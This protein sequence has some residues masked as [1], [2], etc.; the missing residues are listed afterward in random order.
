[1]K[2]WKV[3][4]K[5]YSSEIPFILSGPQSF[6]RHVGGQMPK[7]KVNVNQLKW[8]FAWVI[9]TIKAILMQ[10]FSVVALSDLEIRRHKISLGR[11]EQV[12]KFR[13]LSLENGF[14]FYKISF[15]AQN[16]SSRHKIDHHVNLSNSSRVK[17]FNFQ[18]FWD[19]LMRKE[20][21]QPPWL[22]NFAKIWSE[23]VLRIKTKSHKVWAS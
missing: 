21:Q 8:N 11:R 20:Q 6:T 15:Y 18:N 23:C 13:Y 5:L 14:N 2:F 22:V 10:N 7:I 19:V 3:Y 1:M 16:R 9:I 17:F 4:P 12:I